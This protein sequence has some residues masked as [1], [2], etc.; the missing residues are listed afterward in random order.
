MRFFSYLIFLDLLEWRH[1]T[2]SQVT[3]LKADPISIFAAAHDQFTG[4]L[5]LA[6]TQREHFQSGVHLFFFGQSQ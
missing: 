6:L 2:H 3:I 4:N 1:P 5:A